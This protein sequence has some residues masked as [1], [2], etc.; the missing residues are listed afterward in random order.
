MI[1][2]WLV[3]LR[4]GVARPIAAGSDWMLHV[5]QVTPDGRA[6]YWGNDRFSFID[7]G[8][9]GAPAYNF[10]VIAGMDRRI[11][12]ERY[13]LPD[14]TIACN[15]ADVWVYDDPSKVREALVRNSPSLRATFELTR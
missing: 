12:S 1:S 13:S 5:D 4:I 2:M 7:D 8:D 14:R 3:R 11:V 6:R 9:H 10:I 15:G